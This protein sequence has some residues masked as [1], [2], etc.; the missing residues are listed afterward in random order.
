[1]NKKLLIAVALLATLAACRDANRAGEATDASGAPATVAAPAAAALP[2][3]ELKTAFESSLPGGI[4]TLPFPYHVAVDEVSTSRKTG[5]VAR[6]VGIEFLEGTVAD[7]D[8]SM[9]A[10]FE[11][12]GYVREAGEKQGKAIR[13][14]Y[15]KAG[16]PDVLVWVRRGIP[17]GERFKLQ[18]PGA[19]GTVYLAWDIAQPQQQ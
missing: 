16:E 11:K 3:V 19:K 14:V 1:M 5:K 12:V 9:A 13:S 8:A 6:E 18:Q 10:E 2:A 7:V 4:S 15:R 17:R